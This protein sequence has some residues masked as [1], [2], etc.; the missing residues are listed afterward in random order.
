MKAKNFPH[1]KVSFD[2]RNHIIV[3]APPEAAP[4]KAD[5]TE[6]DRI[7]KN[8]VLAFRNNGRNFI[9]IQLQPP[10]IANEVTI[11]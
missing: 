7:F 6:M 11:K 2:I 1:V 9:C 5:T 10:H 8:G 4:Y 3:N